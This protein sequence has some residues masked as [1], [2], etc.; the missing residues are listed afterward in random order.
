MKHKHYEMI[1]A[2]AANMDLVVFYK[3]PCEEW[4]QPDSECESLPDEVEIDYFLCL[5]Q[6]KDACLHWLNTGEVQGLVC[7]KWVDLYQEDMDMSLP[8]SFRCKLNEFR[9]KPRKEKR[10]IGVYK[11]GATTDACLLRKEAENHPMI[12]DVSVND[13]QFIEIEVEV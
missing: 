8:L 1:M 10:W 4:W 11:N 13:W 3:L 12:T 9:I 5:P 6:H 2:K 7:G